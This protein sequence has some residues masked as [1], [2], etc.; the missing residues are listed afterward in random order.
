[1]DLPVES[2]YGA[3]FVRKSRRSFDDQPGDAAVLGGLD[4]RFASFHPFPGA[5]VALV[6]RPPEAVLR[7]LVGNYGRIN[8]APAYA[9]FIGQ[10]DAPRVQAAVGYAGEAFILEATTLGLATCWVS[11]FF[12]PDAVRAH[13]AVDPSERVFAVTPV[14]PGADKYTGRDRVYRTLARSDSRKPLSEIIDPAG[15]PL[16]S[17]QQKAFE[18]ARLAPSAGNRQPWRFS[19]GP[20]Y[21]EIGA[22][23]G[24][25]NDR[26]SKRLDCGI[27]MLHL[28]LAARTE[29]KSGAWAWLDYPRIA[30]YEINV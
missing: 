22:A 24:R 1:M 10:T 12:R 25:D 5:R 18:A 27:A 14:G 8:G 16:E 21:V 28:E 7:G 23:G 11:G 20:G 9:A 2:W 30:R 13:I 19:A 4:R 6:P 17:W 29:G 15:G 3:I 26:F